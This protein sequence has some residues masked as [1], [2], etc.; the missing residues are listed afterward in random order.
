MFAVSMLLLYFP[1]GELPGKISAGRTPNSC[2]PPAAILGKGGSVLFALTHG[3]RWADRGVH[4]FSFT[5]CVSMEHYLF[6]V[7]WGGTG[8]VVWGDSSAKPDLLV[9][10]LPNSCYEWLIN[11]K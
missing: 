4:L 1:N 9:S 3:L 7:G 6:G 5:E 2:R 8:V 11:L 10:V